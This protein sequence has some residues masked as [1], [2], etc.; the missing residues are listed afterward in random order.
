[1]TFDELRNV[2][3]IKTHKL[4]Y[5]KY[6]MKMNHSCFAG[7]SRLGNILQAVA[8]TQQLHIQVTRRHG[9]ALVPDQERLGLVGEYEG[10]HG[11]PGVRHV[12]GAGS[13]RKPFVVVVASQLFIGSLYYNEQ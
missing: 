12:A 4:T 1:M 7:H 10:Q 11:W 8:A 3:S 9:L 2:V 5:Y 13:F 6:V